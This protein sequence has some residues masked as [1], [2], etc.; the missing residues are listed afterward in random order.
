[1]PKRDNAPKKRT[2]KRVLASNA[3]EF[4][5]RQENW[6]KELSWAIKA[7]QY[8]DESAITKNRAEYIKQLKLLERRVKNYEKKHPGEKLNVPELS[9]ENAPERVT[10]KDIENIKAIRRKK[11]EERAEESEPI[12]IIM[13]ELYNLRNFVASYYNP[14]IKFPGSLNQAKRSLL[15]LLD[16]AIAEQGESVIAQRAEEFAAARDFAK[17][18]M[19]ESH[20]ELQKYS[21]DS[22]SQV[23]FNRFFTFDELLNMEYSLEY[24]ENFSEP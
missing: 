13:L 21:I 23:L 9:L 24:N 7:A 20:G 12:D 17:Q 2:T 19:D 6:Y 4:Q 15:V 18:A 3:E 16:T 8:D 11:L 22:F 5:Y 10:K 14:D 1:M